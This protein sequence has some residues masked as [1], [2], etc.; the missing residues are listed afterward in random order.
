VT[1]GADNTAP[2]PL[3][4]LRVLDVGR[5][6]A[7]PYC[8]TLLGDLGADVIRVER[9]GGGED[10]FVVPVT[11]SGEGGSF[12]QLARN[13]RSVC[14]DLSSPAGRRALDELARRADVIVA[15]LP[16]AELARLGLDYETVRAINPRAVL[17]TMSAYGETG[18]NAGK[19]GFDGV[20]QVMS[21][22]A[23]LSGKP[24]EPARWAATYVDYGT[25][26]G[27]AFGTLA[28][29][30]SR[31]QT[32]LGQHVTGSLL[33]TALTFFNSNLMEAHV[34]QQDREPSG[35]RGQQLAPCDIFATTDGHI[36]IQVLGMA[37]FRKLAAL[38]GE[39][40]WPDDPR[41]Q[42]DE[43]RG[44]HGE[45][46]NRGVATWCAARSSSNALDA[47][48]AAR[49]PAEQVLTPLQVF[50]HP[51][52]QAGDFFRYMSYPG[53]PAPIP[54]VSP[55]VELS[56]TPPTYRS[57]APTAGQHTAEVLREIGFSDAEIVA[58][59]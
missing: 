4:G 43:D 41:F 39:P 20:G 25:A 12:L 19:T 42:T 58:M 32:G 30:M 15:N 13:K 33:K 48:A 17:T 26:L 29:L 34:R 49:I 11:P 9:K 53:A 51:H 22:A 1:T 27:C 16:A 37:Q 3:Q 23:F 57:S 56:A 54:V 50:R 36:L 7:G 59:G 47:L 21:G 40:A 10:R 35:S 14:L 28:A 18:P 6:I 55:Q 52:I 31:Q 2:P 38:I 44:R 45:F 8:A 46:I 5:F 24:G